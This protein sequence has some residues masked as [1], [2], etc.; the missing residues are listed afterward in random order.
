MAPGCGKQDKKKSLYEYS[1]VQTRWSSSENPNGIAGNGGKANNRAKGH[2]YDSIPSGKAI[3]LLNISGTG[4]INRIW[5]TIDDR[6]PEMLRALRI[7]MYW[8]DEAKPRYL[9]RWVIFLV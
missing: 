8:D 2:P 7:D 9:L 3:E 6:S 1:E 5:L 4:L